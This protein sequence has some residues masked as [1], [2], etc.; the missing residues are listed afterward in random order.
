M[1]AVRFGFGNNWEDLLN[2][3]G[4][5]EIVSAERSLHR[6]IP[7]KD[8]KGKKFLD[9]GSGSGLFSL[10]AWNWNAEVYSFDYDEN[11]V[12]CTMRLK[13]SVDVEKGRSWDIEQ[14]DVLDSSYMKKF[15]GKYDVV[16]SWGVL[17]HTG[18]MEKALMEAGKCVVPGGYLFISI[19][20]DQGFMSKIWRYVKKTYNLSGKNRRKIILFMASL[21]LYGYQTT[22]HIYKNGRNVLSERG[23]NAWND[24]VDWVGGYP[25]EYATAEK[26]VMF[27][28]GRGFKL[29]KLK[30]LDKKN[31]GCNQFV[32]QKNNIQEHI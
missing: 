16:Y 13:D 21:Y 20:N 18:N 14:G 8:L 19:Y 30:A 10:A 15:Y 29:V 17:H 12:K 4:K 9:I 25:F 7:Y 22:R 23:M 31:H 6:W 5:E 11:S 27:Y 24:L 28:L 1:K 2:N 32:F 26:I 3:I